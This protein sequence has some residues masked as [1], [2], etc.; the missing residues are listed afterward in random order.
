MLRYRIA[1]ESDYPFLVEL[2]KE[3]GW[4]EAKLAAGWSDPDRIFCVLTADQ[5]VGMACWCL[6][7]LNGMASEKDG[8]VHIG[9]STASIAK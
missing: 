6:E 4:G 3:C 2:R 5:D 1:Q 9:R 7:Y 8:I